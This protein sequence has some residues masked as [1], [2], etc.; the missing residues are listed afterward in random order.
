MKNSS[1]AIAKELRSL[2]NLTVKALYQV[3]EKP[4]CESFRLAINLT[5]KGPVSG[6]DFTCANKAN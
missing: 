5:A 3:I 4:A 6:H 2:K 1:S